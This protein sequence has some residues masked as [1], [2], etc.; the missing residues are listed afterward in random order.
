MPTTSVTLGRPSVSVPVLSNATSVSLPSVST[1]APP[2]NSSPCRAPVASAAAIAAGVDI[3]R[4]QGQP[5]SSRASPRYTQSLQAAP[6][7]SGGAI[8]TTIAT[9]TT[10]G[11]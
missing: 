2:L 6:A 10:H 7:S 3:T 1:T 8:A 4:A 9:T 11:V 5:I